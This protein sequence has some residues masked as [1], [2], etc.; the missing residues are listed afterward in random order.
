M[1]TGRSPNHTPYRD[2]FLHPTTIFLSVHKAASTFLTVEMADAMTRVFPELT[3]VALAQEIVNGKRIESLPIAATNMV[4]TRVYPD[5][6]ETLVESPVPE[7]GRFADKKLIMLRRDPRDVAV[8]LYY[9]IRFSHTTKT[10]N[11]KHFLSRKAVLADLDVANGIAEITHKPSIKQFQATEAF[12]KKHPQTCLTTYE[13][14]VGDLPAWIDRVKNHLQWT[15]DQAA[16]ISRG[17]AKA[18]KA[19]AKADPARHKRRVTPGNW[20][21][22]FDD[23]LREIY[24][25]LIGPELEAA[26][27]LW[28]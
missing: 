11:K 15:D 19:P 16:S 8:S 24:D 28:E 17:L 22:V 3:H 6:Y 4:V 25:R 23:R 5:Q 14:L 21:D 9:S 18:V 27:Y 1:L 2:Q 13:M 20:K 7:A 10:R 26:G 12:L